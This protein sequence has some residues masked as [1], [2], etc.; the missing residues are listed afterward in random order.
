MGIRSPPIS[1]GLYA[2][3]HDF[4]IILSDGSAGIKMHHPH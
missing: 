4:K 3:S 2:V 1:L